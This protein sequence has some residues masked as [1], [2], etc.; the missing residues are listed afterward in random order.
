[1]LIDNIAGF[2]PSTKDH[3][4]I[5]LPL[6]CQRWTAY[7][8]NLRPYQSKLSWPPHAPLQCSPNTLAYFGCGGVKYL[9]V[10]NYVTFDK[11]YWFE[12]LTTK[13]QN[14]SAI[15]SWQAN[16]LAYVASAKRRSGNSIRHQT[17]GI[18][19][20]NF[21]NFLPC[22]T[23]VINFFLLATDGTKIS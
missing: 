4:S 16:A 12:V 5:V 17:G 23:L 10:L 9:Y 14:W 13:W 2:E 18:C 6:R 11:S 3:E 22:L 15:F 21:F 8:R 1:M 20:N 7:M 19:W